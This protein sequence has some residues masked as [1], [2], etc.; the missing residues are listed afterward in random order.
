M[1]LSA[2]E[3]NT[4]GGDKGSSGTASPVKK[5]PNRP[6]WE[7]LKLEEPREEVD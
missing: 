2:K 4:E 3:I 1:E 7:G 6:N 5:M